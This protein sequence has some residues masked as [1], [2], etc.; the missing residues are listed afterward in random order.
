MSKSDKYLGLAA[1]FVKDRFGSPSTLRYYRQEWWIWSQGRY[2]VQSEDDLTGMMVLWLHEEEEDSRL[3]AVRELRNHIRVLDC[4]SVAST[5]D[6][7]LYVN[8][9]HY[10]DT[11]NFLAFQDC[12]IDLDVL[13]SGPIRPIRLRPDSNWFSAVVMSYNYEPEATCPQFHVF[14]DKVLPDKPSQDVLQEWFGYCLTKDNS[15]RKLM[16]LFGEARTGKSTLSNILEAVIGP[17]NR[18]AVPLECFWNRFS[19][20]EMVGKLVNFCGDCNQIDRLAEGVIKRFTGGDTILVDRKYKDPVSL[21]MTAKIIVATNVFPQVKDPSEA[22]WDRFIV[23]PMNVRIQDHEID[24][25]LLNSEKTSWPLRW[26]LPGIFNW[27]IEGLKRLKR[28]GKFTTSQVFEQAKTT[29]R[30]ENCSLSQFV[31]ERCNPDPSCSE[32]TSRFM[33]EYICFCDS[34][35]LKAMNSSQVGRTLRKLIPGMEKKRMGSRYEQQMHYVGLQ[36]IVPRS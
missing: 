29:V 19:P 22:L 21:K 18:S 5:V 2:R 20:H 34:M 28:Q 35:N 4:V 25:S 24:L 9:D 14:L 33:N 7:P 36:I 27:A 10:D 8:V 30:H 1:R 17:E 16:I 13:A 31:D 15:F 3:A 6:M 11:S 23:V 26:E 12:L 32:T